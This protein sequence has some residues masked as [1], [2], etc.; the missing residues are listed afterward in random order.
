MPE[1]GRPLEA[2]LEH[3]EGVFARHHTAIWRYL[4]RLG[5][6]QRADDLAGE[7]FLVAFTRRLSYDPSRGSVS[8]WLYGIA[9]NLLRNQ[10]RSERRRTRA[11]ERAAIDQVIVTSPMEDIDE[12]RTRHVRLARIMEAMA[13]LSARD[14]EILVLFA[15]ERL[16]YQEIA[17][18][19]DMELGTV[20]S[21]LSRSRLRLRELASLGSGAAE[22]VDER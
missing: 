12:Q 1:A 13:K 9:T 11:F 22:E 16:S 19:L 2:E 17:S 4:A 14:R 10:F 21:R 5:G 18:A 7:V 6:R 8:A 15:W 20:R 3:F